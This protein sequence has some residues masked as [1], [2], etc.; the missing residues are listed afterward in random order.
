MDTF[1]TTPGALPIAHIYF[2]LDVDEG[3]IERKVTSLASFIENLGG[4]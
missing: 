2:R 3:K 4:I 1:K